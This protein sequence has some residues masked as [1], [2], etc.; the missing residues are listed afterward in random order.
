[1]V[2]CLALLLAAAP[3][4]ALT[5]AQELLAEFNAAEALPL[6]ERAKDEDRPFSHRDH[7][8]LYEQLGIGYAY[9]GR[10]EEAKEA[11]LRALALEPRL[12]ISYTLSPKV[13]FLFEQAREKA[14]RIGAPAIDVSW[15]SEPSVIEAIPVEVEVL[16]DPFQFLRQ[17]VVF[18]R[19][20]GEAQYRAEPVALPGPGQRARVLLPAAAL[21]RSA[22][23][24]L[25]VVVRDEHDSE[26]LLWRSADRPLAIPLGYDPP[27][28]WYTS[29]WVLALA[30]AVAVGATTAAVVATYEP[31]SLAGGAIRW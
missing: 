15:P 18:H 11:F 24:E 14:A 3:S 17:A 2:P 22:T 25:F 29:W 26:V 4:P 28:P 30:G 12:A 21:D 31:S 10:A 7:L 23:L 8:T 1:M 27:A 19:L 16:A 6:I 13:T 9:L 20:A 5:K